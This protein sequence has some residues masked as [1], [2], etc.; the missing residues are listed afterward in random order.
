MIEPLGTNPEHVASRRVLTIRY[1]IERAQTTMAVRS[2]IR[3]AE[4]D[5]RLPAARLRE[6]VA[7]GAARIASIRALR[8]KRGRA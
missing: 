6:L 8:T 1:R 4:D 5:I 2:A 3:A 7:Y